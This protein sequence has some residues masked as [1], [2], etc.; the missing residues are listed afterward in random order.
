MDPVT[1]GLPHREPFIFVDSVIELNPGDSAI[2]SKLFNEN[3]PYFLGH[4]PG[5][6][7]VPGVLL[8]EALAQT[9]G[10]AIGASGKTFLLTAVRSMKFLSPVRPGQSVMLT[11]K[12]AADMN[13]LIQCTVQAQV[14]SLIVAEGQIILTESANA[15]SG[16]KPKN[17]HSESLNVQ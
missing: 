9:A 8:L 7:I 17:E 3:E 13:G 5:N 10:I 14:G 6:A 1:L 4:F 16:P 15:M 2:A 11:A 12:K